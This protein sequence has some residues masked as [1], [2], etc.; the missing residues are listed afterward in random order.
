MTEIATI[1]GLPP[2]RSRRWYDDACGAAMAMEL[3]GERWSIFVVRELM[4]GARR[5]SQLRADLPGISANVL[6]QRLEALDAVGVVGR[7][8]LP[9]PASVQVYELTEWGQAAEPMLL[10]MCR[11]ALSSPAHA[12]LAHLS[13]IAM[14]LSLKA[15]FDPNALVG[16][17]MR[18]GF[19]IGEDAFVAQPVADGPSLRLDVER[20]VDPHIGVDC[21]LTGSTLTLRW[22]FYGGRPIA[23]MVAEGAL[24]LEG[25]VEAAQR[26]ARAFRFPEKIALTASVG[27]V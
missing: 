27:E 1:A 22:V 3:I 16:G 15:L 6:T 24:R 14:M 23:E 20:V 18:V 10:D 7:R 5:F 26:F 4:F 13:P 12:P 11:W 2:G 25:D 8:M 21:C 9:P 17:D 19:E